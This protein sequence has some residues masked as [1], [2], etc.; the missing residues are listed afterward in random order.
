MPKICDSKFSQ[1]VFGQ[2]FFKKFGGIFKGATLE[3]GFLRAVALKLHGGVKVSTGVVS[4]GKR[5]V[6]RNHLKIRIFLNN[7]RQKSNVNGC[8]NGSPSHREVPRSLC[9]RQ[10]VVNVNR[11]VS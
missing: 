5:V 7:K 9:R 11:V 3:T 8:L 6:V 1:K 2:T 10:A 4:I